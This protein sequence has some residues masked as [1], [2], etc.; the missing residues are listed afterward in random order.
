MNVTK[1]TERMSSVHPLVPALSVT[2]LVADCVV[3][4]SP[5]RDFL[6]E[7]MILSTYTHSPSGSA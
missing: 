2:P 6:K 1:H 5:S 7:A 3:F 4:F